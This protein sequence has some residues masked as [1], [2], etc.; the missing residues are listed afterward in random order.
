MKKII[1]IL[2]V[3]AA[4][5]CSFL[6]E[7]QPTGI[8]EVYDTEMALEA[9]LRGIL[10]SLDNAGSWTGEANEKIFSG[11][12]IVHWSMTQS[13]TR[14]NSTEWT[15]ALRFTSSSSAST[16]SSFFSNHYYGIDKCN[17]LLAALPSSPVD[18]EYKRGVE[19]ET[20]FYRGFYYFNVVRFW[21]DAPLRL[22]A[23]NVTNTSVPREK[24]DRIY[25]QVIRD[26]EKAA[27]LMR[28][29][30]QVK[31]Q[32]PGE[33]RPHRF[34]PYAYLSTVYLTIGSLLSHHED[35]FWNPSKEGRAPD[36]SDLKIFE[37]LNFP[38]QSD[39]EY[40]EAARLAYQESLRYAEMLIPETNPES[41]YKLCYKYTDLYAWSRDFQDVYGNDAW[42]LPERIFVYSI[43]PQASS[44]YLAKRTLPRFVDGTQNLVKS[45]GNAARQRPDRWF[46]QKWCETYP[47]AK[48]TNSTA[49]IYVSSSDPRLDATMYHCSYYDQAAQKTQNIYPKYIT[50]PTHYY[51]MPY[52]KK[53]F[54]P[55]YDYNAG[56]ADLYF[57]RLTE[58]YLNA[59]E[60]AAFIGEE[61]K[62]YGYIGILHDRARRTKSGAGQP[63]WTS[64]QFDSKEK[65]MTAIFW[66]RMFELCGEAG[67]E[68]FDTH[69]FGAT[70]LVKNIS[71]PKNVFL[72]LKEQSDETTYGYKM[73]NAS[74]TYK[75]FYYGTDFSY[76]EDPEEARK[77]L[78]LAFPS[79][80]QYYNNKIESIKNDYG[81]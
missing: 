71:E 81:F 42:S 77:G 54:S 1:F 46:Y 67:H 7:K 66:E 45:D 55:E 4:V 6:D 75:D 8:K 47:G 31:E 34:A 36:F 13:T 64:G 63:Q 17:T 41:P 78:L 10:V 50:N 65:L 43:T 27:E 51:G 52:F 3:L 23:S 5:S 30:Q 35:N 44:S 70:W 69:R 19:G 73:G 53:Y 32:V 22:E 29:P 9:N 26:F 57:M 62:A 39:A 24:Y 80:E 40:Q 59:A 60:A 12:G 33:S 14:L 25:V 21:G 2:T 20:L 11:S 15:E 37:D 48:G 18:E 28:T 79:R 72:N 61:A 49:D 56:Y 76:I 38:L 68:W 16:A 74:M 58:M